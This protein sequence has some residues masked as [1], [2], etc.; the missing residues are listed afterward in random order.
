MGRCTP[1]GCAGRSEARTQGAPIA[2]AIGATEDAASG[3]A[4]RPCGTTCISPTLLEGWLTAEEETLEG[5]QEL[6]AAER[7]DLLG[8]AVV[9]GDDGIVLERSVR[10]V[11]AVVEL[12]A[13][14]HVVVSA[15]LL[16]LPVL[17]IDLPADGPHGTRPAFDPDEHPLGATAV[18]ATLHDAF[19]E[20]PGDRGALH[21]TDYTIAPMGL[22]DAVTGAFSFL[23]GG[24]QKEE[25]AAQYVIREHHRGRTLAEILDDPY[26]R[27]RF[28]PQ[29]AERLLDRPEIIRAVGDQTIEQTRSVRTAR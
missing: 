4:A 27:N 14:P 8:C 10:R 13:R 17:R 22:R 21:A 3:R 29:Q 9:L 18:V 19:G 28:T 12:V 26:V 20:P 7:V 24:S 2:V 16:R 15:R 5:S 23:R 25:R 1:S 6:V 11:E